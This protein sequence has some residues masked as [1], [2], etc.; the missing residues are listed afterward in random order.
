MISEFRCV[1]WER[2]RTRTRH[3]N[4]RSGKIHAVR[5]HSATVQFIK[6]DRVYESSVSFEI[7]HD[8]VVLSI[9]S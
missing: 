2:L 8:A 3:R 5:V 6:E 4:A 1:V 9:S 7:A